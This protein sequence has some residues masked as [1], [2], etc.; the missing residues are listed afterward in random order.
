MIRHLGL[1]VC[2]FALAAGPAVAMAQS[3]VVGRNF[4][5][6][7]AAI[8]PL[9]PDTMGAVGVDYYVEL[10]NHKYNVYRKSDGVQVQS[11]GINQFWT[12]ANTSPLMTPFD[13]RIVYDPRA[14]RWY[15][16]AVDSRQS[17]NNILFAIS[18]SADPTQAWTG[19]SFDS[20]ADDSNW[21]DFP[22]LGYNNEAVWISSYMPT[23]GAAASGSS[24]I[25]LFKLDLLQPTPDVST[26]VQFEDVPQAVAGTHP[27]L[28]VD[29]SPYGGN[30]MSLSMS[31]FGGGSI[32]RADVG[33]V[34]PQVNNTG[35]L[36]AAAT[37]PPTVVQPGA[38]AVQNLEA[39]DWRFSSN[40]VLQGQYLYGVQAVEDAGRA[41]VR[42]VV[43]DLLT[44]SVGTEI[45]S[46]PNLAFSFPSIAVNGFG[47]V[48]IGVTGTSSSEYASSYALVRPAGAGL[49]E[50]PRLL[51]AGVDNYEQLDSLSRN[52]W[53]DYSAT[54][55][56]PADPSIFWTNQEYVDGTNR[57]ATQVTELILPRPGEA[58]WAEPQSGQFDDAAL[59]LTAHG[60]AP[61][62]SDQLVFSRATEP[63]AAPITITLPPPVSGA[64][65]FPDA[66]F[67]QG[68]VVLDLGGN[69]LD[70]LLQLEVGPYEGSPH[71][72]L[73]NGTVTSVAGYIA[74]GDTSEGHLT[75]DNAQWHVAGD[76]YIGSQGGTA[77][78]PG[79]FGGTGSVTID[80]GSQLTVDGRVKIWQAGSINLDDGTLT[81]MSIDAGPAPGHFN[82]NG[83]TLHVNDFAGE[84]VNT[85]GTLAPGVGIGTTNV[86]PGYFQMPGGAIS[87][88]IGGLGL[89]DFDRVIAGFAQLDGTLDVS[90]VGGFT[91]AVGDSFDVF[92]WGGVLGTFATINLPAL[93]GGQRWDLSQLYS[94][95]ELSVLPP[96]DADFDEDR[97]VDGADLAVWQTGYGIVGTATHT[98]GDADANH[99]VNGGDFLIWQRQYGSIAPIAAVPEPAALS[100]LALGGL[101]LAAGRRTGDDSR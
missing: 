12:D 93:P 49:F 75:L 40:T 78:F 23:L 87:I 51:R 77:G 90:L 89:A 79:Q 68:N 95:G 46:D 62:P 91:P 54:T 5:G 59:W 14:R 80:N 88:E 44:N 82:F 41:A 1:S 7:T 58:R 31:S 32:T 35:T 67:R 45:I 37:Q 25:G 94:T 20:D 21:A 61:L 86:A 83:G 13:P 48:V 55:V 29:T 96:F 38:P 71:A 6:T 98:Q 3:V 97:D 74:P 64:Y 69:Q 57:W 42:M 2:L 19:F 47:D 85:G 8:Q 65:S 30:M 16:V 60:N 73:A 26:K 22:M 36:Y 11:K 33:L 50:P 34:S 72:T 56:D 101:A 15:A 24:F 99:N 28:V 18:S 70:L 63:G 92:D 84:L 52:R 53:G 39:N 27:Q 43:V 4:Q 17:A 81:A 100:L 9:T 10:N 76:L 66:S